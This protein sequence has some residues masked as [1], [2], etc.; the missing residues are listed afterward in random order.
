MA[1]SRQGVGAAICSDHDVDKCSRALRPASAV[2][3]RTRK[4]TQTFGSIGSINDPSGV[5]LS[6]KDYNRLATRC[7]ARDS[8]GAG[9]EFA[10]GF[11]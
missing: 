3:Y 9:K 5:C 4:Q 10:V 6:L 8:P 1:K 7:R 2:N 11:S